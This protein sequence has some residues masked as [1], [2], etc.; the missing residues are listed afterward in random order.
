ML[1]YNAYLYYDSEH[2]KFR[3]LLFIEKLLTIKNS[4]KANFQRKLEQI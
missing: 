1:I 4:L 2:W 3:L